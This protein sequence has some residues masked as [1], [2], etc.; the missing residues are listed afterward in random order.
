LYVNY[1][2]TAGRLTSGYMRLSELQLVKP[3]M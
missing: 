1:R 3:S 2:N